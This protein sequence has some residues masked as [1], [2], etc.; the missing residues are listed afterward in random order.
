[1][2]VQM[3]KLTVKPGALTARSQSLYA[4]SHPQGG[5]LTLVPSPTFSLSP[6]P[7]A[8]E[9]GLCLWQVTCCNKVK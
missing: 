5:W 6:S 9:T 3:G 1:M 4:G 7:L 8:L 2:M